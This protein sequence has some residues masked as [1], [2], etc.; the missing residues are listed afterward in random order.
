V[1]SKTLRETGYPDKAKTNSSGNYFFSPIKIGNY[2][3]SASAPGITAPLESVTT[4][5]M[6]P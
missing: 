1:S 4:P 6:A 2:T 3:V 5:M